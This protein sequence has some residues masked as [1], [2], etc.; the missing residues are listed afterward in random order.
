MKLS[1][2]FV[3]QVLV[4]TPLL[5]S[6]LVANL[7]DRRN[8]TMYSISKVEQLFPLLAIIIHNFVNSL[9]ELCQRNFVVFQQCTLRAFSVEKEKTAEKSAT[10]HSQHCCLHY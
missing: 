6:H 4:N 1:L 8:Y 10:P 9:Y 5:Y 3:I 2:V 7:I